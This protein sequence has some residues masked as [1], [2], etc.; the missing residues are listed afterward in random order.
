MYIETERNTDAK[1]SVFPSIREERYGWRAES[2]LSSFLRV[3]EKWE[4]ERVILF[5]FRPVSVWKLNE[6]SLVPVEDHRLCFWSSSLST[7]CA[8][9]VSSPRVETA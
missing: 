7:V 2:S 3:L 1:A 8:L 4:Y 6:D 5:F 9:L